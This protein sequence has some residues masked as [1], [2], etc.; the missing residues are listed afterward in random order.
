LTQAQLLQLT[1]ELRWP[2]IEA[3]RTV[4]V[5]GDV[6]GVVSLRSFLVL[7]NDQQLVGELLR[8]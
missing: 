4:R 6:H 5:L 2:D 3:W 1:R 7:Y 8:V